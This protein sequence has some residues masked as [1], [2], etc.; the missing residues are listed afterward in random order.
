MSKVKTVRISTD[1]DGMIGAVAMVVA[2]VKSGC[3]LEENGLY[4]SMTE[5]ERDQVRAAL[6]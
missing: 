2:L 5:A 1:N 3:S 6:A 4:R